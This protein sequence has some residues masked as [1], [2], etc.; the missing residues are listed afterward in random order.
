MQLIDFLPSLL[1]RIER[2]HDVVVVERHTRHVEVAV[3]V[4]D[5]NAESGR[6]NI[7]HP[8]ALNLASAAAADIDARRRRALKILLSWLRVLE[9]VKRRELTW[10]HLDGPR[11]QLAMRL[12]LLLRLMIVVWVR[13]RRRCRRLDAPFTLQFGGRRRGIAAA[14]IELLTRY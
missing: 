4:V 13:R 14:A 7:G 1:T 2:M 9:A 6:R 12:A 5:H 10:P 11:R 8:D 3:D